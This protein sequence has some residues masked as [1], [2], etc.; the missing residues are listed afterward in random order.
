MMYENDRNNMKR[1]DISFVGLGLLRLG[2]AGVRLGYGFV[3]QRGVLVVRIRG[4]HR[5]DEVMFGN[6]GACKIIQL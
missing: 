1:E 2:V 5:L 4:V 6:V 3:Y